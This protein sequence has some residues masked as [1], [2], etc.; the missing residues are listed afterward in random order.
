MKNKFLKRSCF[1][2]L[3]ILLLLTSG[4]SM[5]GTSNLFPGGRVDENAAVIRTAAPFYGSSFIT[6]LEIDGRKDFPT[7][8]WDRTCM[9]FVPP[10][11]YTV[12]VKNS[13]KIYRLNINTEANH[14]YTIDAS[15]AW[16]MDPTP[17]VK[18]SIK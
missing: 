16:W 18:D 4:C 6:I 9:I 12:T 11:R 5:G 15:G 2:S 10:G 1:Y 3:C 17:K 8:M 14:V 13:G 7:S